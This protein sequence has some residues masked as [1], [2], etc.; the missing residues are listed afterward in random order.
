M[1]HFAELMPFLRS[2]DVKNFLGIPD[3]GKVFSCDRNTVDCENPATYR[4]MKLVRA[5]L[6]AWCSST[7]SFSLEK[8]LKT[9]LEREFGKKIHQLVELGKDEMEIQFVMEIDD[10]EK[11]YFNAKVKS[12][13]RL[14]ELD[15]Y[16]TFHKESDHYSLFEYISATQLR[17]SKELVFDPLQVDEETISKKKKAIIGWVSK[18][19]GAEIIKGDASCIVK[20]GAK[21]PSCQ[22]SEED[23]KLIGLAN[24]A[25]TK[26]FKEVFFY[27]FDR[28]YGSFGSNDKKQAFDEFV[29]HACNNN[30]QVF[31]L[32]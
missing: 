20:N 28:G 24:F 12:K 19:I 31:V 1:P 4:L 16:R 17:P 8:N 11:L 6:Q 22:Q 3:H 32:K 21:I 26:D 10:Y 30:A 15:S 29:N 23:Q 2:V 27:F 9:F 18:S 5:L 13:C 7:N 14:I 25:L